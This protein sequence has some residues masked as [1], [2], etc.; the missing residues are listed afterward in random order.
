M[1]RRNITTKNNSLLKIE[2][3]LIR[4]KVMAGKKL[5]AWQERNTKALKKWKGIEIIRSFREKL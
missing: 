4:K 1:L 5:K 2:E 3:M